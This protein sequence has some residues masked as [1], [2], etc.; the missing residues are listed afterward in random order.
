MKSIL[1]T[2][3]QNIP[4]KSVE[5]YL[6]KYIGCTYIVKAYGDYI[7]VAG[8]FPNEYSESKYTKSLRG[9]VAKAK[10]NAAQIIESLVIHA[11]NRRWVE[12]KEEKHKR[13]AMEGWYRYD[14]NFSI[15]VKGSNEDEKRKNVYHATLVVRKT[16]K[17]LFLYDVINIKKEASTPL[18]S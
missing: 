9:G 16:S 6:K 1:F 5:L 17:G 15:L 4:W 10:A 8:D 18:K 2:G 13:N 12:N 14:S 7:S 11:V 3:K